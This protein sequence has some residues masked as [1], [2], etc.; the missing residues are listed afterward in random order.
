MRTK[1]KTLFLFKFDECYCLDSIPKLYEDMIITENEEL[2]NE[3][4]ICLVR[5]AAR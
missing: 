2:K 5:I 3:I 4:G 1:L